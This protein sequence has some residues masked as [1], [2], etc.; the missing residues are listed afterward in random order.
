[1]YKAV[2]DTCVLVP[3]LQRDFLLQLAV[4]NAYAAV[5][6]TGILFELDYVLARIYESRGIDTEESERR[7]IRLFDRM[8]TAFPGSTIE[9]AKDRAYDYELTDPDDGHVAHAAI[10]GK[11][12]A[13]V[14]DDGRA[15][16]RTS[17]TLLA[18]AI[19][20]LSPAEF[21]ANTVAA[22][23]EAGLR[24]L[25]VIAERRRTTPAVLL[26]EL[27]DRYEMDDVEATLGALL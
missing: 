3:G 2:L 1:M 5:W 20:T 4:E 9:A 6:G 23:P 12:D 25:E 21:A 7:L 18:A 15:G 13:I 26:A 8:S 14:T 22:H 24:A 11:A 10:M 27:R 16:F 19:E 17:S